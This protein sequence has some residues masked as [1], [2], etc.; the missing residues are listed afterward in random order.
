MQ[1]I[2]PEKIWI[3]RTIALEIICAVVVLSGNAQ[4]GKWDQSTAGIDDRSLLTNVRFPMSRRSDEEYLNEHGIDVR[5]VSPR[6]WLHRFGSFFAIVMRGRR[7][8][9]LRAS[10]RWLWQLDKVL[11]KITGKPRDQSIGLVGL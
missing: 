8:E 1:I 10:S 4:K 11:V 2:I 5:C 3:K 6:L 7:A 9:R